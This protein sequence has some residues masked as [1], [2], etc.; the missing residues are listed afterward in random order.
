MRGL[1]F[2]L[3]LFAV[4]QF[5]FA[6]EAGKNDLPKPLPDDVVKAWKDAGAT[7]GWMKEDEN[8]ILRFFEKAE[9][10]A[11]PAFQLAAWKDGVVAKLPMPKAPFGLYLAKT[12]IMD[13]SLKELTSLRTLGSLCLCETPT[14]AQAV[15]ELRKALPKCFIFHC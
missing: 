8:G 13:G 5:G 15:E 3:A 2:A 10:G 7:V 12:E 14:T 9:A 11:I 6:G 4:S 1:A